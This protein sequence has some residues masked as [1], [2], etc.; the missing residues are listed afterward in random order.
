MTRPH[1]I[2]AGFV[3]LVALTGTLV[4]GGAMA[5]LADDGLEITGPGTAAAG[6]VTITGTKN[7]A[8][9]GVI[10]RNSPTVAAPL[11]CN[12]AATTETTWEC[13]APLETGYR[14]VS[15]Y[16]GART[17]TFGIAVGAFTAPIPDDPNPNV[18]HGE[19]AHFSGTVEFPGGP[20]AW[21]EVSMRGLSTSCTDT[22]RRCPARRIAATH[23]ECHPGQASNASAIRGE[24]SSAYPG[25]S[26]QARGYNERRR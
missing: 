16:Q 14:V 26:G 22:R 15:A 18:P 7:A 23:L 10:V 3:A 4:F 17:A 9:S 5:A 13:E 21:V 11:L 20:G 25:P 19:W 1:R 24:R 2:A 6:N 12:I 8:A